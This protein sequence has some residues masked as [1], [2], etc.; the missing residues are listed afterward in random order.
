MREE[1]NYGYTLVHKEIELFH[2]RRQHKNHQILF[3]DFNEKLV[4]ATTGVTDVSI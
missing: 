1:L 4:G 3:V 2:Y